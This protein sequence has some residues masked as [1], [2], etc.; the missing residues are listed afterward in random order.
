MPRPA[1]ARKKDLNYKQEE[2]ELTESAAKNDSFSRLSVFRGYSVLLG[3]E[4][5]VANK[6]LTNF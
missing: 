5:G 3:R 2:T 6:P 4:F 1:K